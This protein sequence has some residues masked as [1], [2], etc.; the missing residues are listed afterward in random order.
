MSQEIR[1]KEPLTDQGAG[2]GFETQ[3]RPERAGVRL[4]SWPSRQNLRT[5]RYPWQCVCKVASAVSGPRNETTMET[6][7]DSKLPRFD[8]LQVSNHWWP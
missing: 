8:P 2:R 1:E 3:P 6:V 7:S 5:P 4:N